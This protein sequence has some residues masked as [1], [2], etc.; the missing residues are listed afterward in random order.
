MAGAIVGERAQSS[1]G[2][3]CHDRNHNR[4]RVCRGGGQGADA[5][6]DG[7]ER[8]TSWLH[9]SGHCDFNCDLHTIG[10]A[11]H[12]SE[13]QLTVKNRVT[14]VSIKR[15]LSVGSPVKRLRFLRRVRYFSRVKQL[16]LSLR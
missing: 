9:Y 13:L 11:G 5:E 12:W 10:L 3:T 2:L 6:D 8:E 15:Q 1:G 4:A 14:T 16:L 7:D